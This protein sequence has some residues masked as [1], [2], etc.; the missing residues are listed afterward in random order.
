MFVPAT[1]YIYVAVRNVHGSRVIKS[2]LAE[3]KKVNSERDPLALGRPSVKFDPTKIELRKSRAGV[4]TGR[5]S[6]E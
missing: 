3:K 6:A 1:E 2:V 4:G 5:W